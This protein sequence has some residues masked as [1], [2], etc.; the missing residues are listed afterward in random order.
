MTRRPYTYRE[1]RSLLEL[2]ANQ[3]AL[4]AEIK[5]LVQA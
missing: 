5:A 2:R 3:E 4:K 1:I